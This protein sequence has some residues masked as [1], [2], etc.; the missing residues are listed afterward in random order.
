[1]SRLVWLWLGLAVVLM[2]SL[3]PARIRAAALTARGRLG[4]RAAG[5]S[6][7]AGSPAAR[8][9]APAAALVAAIAATGAAAATSGPALAIAVLIA[10]ATAARLAL[11]ARARRRRD[12]D[13]AKVLAALRLVG[14]ELDAGAPA[15]A[16]LAAAADQ[17]AEQAP[18]HATQLRTAA[19]A[20]AA[21]DPPAAGGPL[22]VLAPAWPLVT[23]TGAPL[24]DVCRRVA[25]DLAVRIDQ[26]RAVASAL[27][28]ARSSAALLAVLPVLG[29]LLGTALQ[30][31]PVAVLLG[32]P[33][34]HGV[35]VAGVGLDAAGLLWTHWLAARAEGP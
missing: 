26:R 22:A 14:A 23:S 3:T 20:V 16:A 6:A 35:L 15:A 31:R 32:T 28:G 19:G 11:A 13:D 17:L 12:G 5:A 8:L 24:A 10:A 1:V 30:A 21:G 4:R 25:D 7:P 29:V 33:A 2:P 18:T 34:G 9:V 27:A